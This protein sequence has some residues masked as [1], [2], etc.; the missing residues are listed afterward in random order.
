MLK[1][2]FLLSIRQELSYRHDATEP[3][4]N[5]R[6]LECLLLFFYVPLCE[7]LKK[8]LIVLEI[9]VLFSEHGKRTSSPFQNHPLLACLTNL[10]HHQTTYR[11]HDSEYL[12]M[13]L[14]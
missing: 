3:Q 2:V 7:G 6:K 11:L 5:N 1:Q 4:P 13:E 8:S 9:P 10:T 12:L 14:A